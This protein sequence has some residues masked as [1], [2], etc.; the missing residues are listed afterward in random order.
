MAEYCH[1][2]CSKCL[3]F[4]RMHARGRPHYS[5]I[6]LLI[7]D[8]VSA[9]LNM[10]QML[11]QFTTLVY[12]K[13]TAIYKDYLTDLCVFKNQCMLHV[14]FCHAMLCISTAY[15]VMWCL[16]VCVCVCVS[17][18]FVSCVETNKR[19]IKIFSP[20]GSHT[21]LVFPCQTA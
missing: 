21:I 9:I 19:I 18:T 4:A 2:C 16:C 5:S 7:I 20:S 14:H 3:P 13:S 8:L 11:L 12:I 15:A 1:N 6:A 17:V 10:Q